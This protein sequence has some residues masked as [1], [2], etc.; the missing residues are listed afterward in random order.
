MN[1]LCALLE[2]GMSLTKACSIVPASPTSSQILD[3][4]VAEPALAEQYALARESGYKVIA[5]EILA[6]ADENY[7]TVEED[8]LDESGSPVMNDD[9][10]RLQRSIKVP[11]SN[12]GIARN[13]LRI[14]SRKWMLSK[15]LP[16]VYGDKL[17]TE[18][19]GPNGGPVQL[20]AV[21]MKNL[22]DDELESMTRMMKKIGTPE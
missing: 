14:D 16:K 18:H 17:Q 11:L 13:R 22:S 4:I 15:M 5:D 8:V 19:T 20:T 10:H 6:I 2:T 12:E 21:D 3:W 1:S 7:T 9:G